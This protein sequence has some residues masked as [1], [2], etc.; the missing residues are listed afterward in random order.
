MSRTTSL[1]LSELPDSA[2]TGERHHYR[3]VVIAGY[4]AGF[5]L[6]SAAVS[7]AIDHLLRGRRDQQPQL[8]GGVPTSQL[9]VWLRS[10]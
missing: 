8:R 7:C 4:F 5:C 10:H 3:L 2:A 6:L 9:G 1:T